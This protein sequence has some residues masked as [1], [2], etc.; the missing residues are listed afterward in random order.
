MS[1]FRYQAIEANGVP[2]RGVIEAD[3]RQISAHI[4]QELR[5]RRYD[6]APSE[7]WA[8]LAGGALAAIISG[9]TLW[10]LIRRQWVNP[11]SGLS[12]TAELMAAG[13]DYA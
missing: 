9:L 5:S 7:V 1:A 3:D 13:A 6:A 2:A 12:A 8:A 10:T 4:M 11:L